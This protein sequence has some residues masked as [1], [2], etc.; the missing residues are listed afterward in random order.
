M[1]PRPPRS[2]LFPYT[3]LFRSSPE[4]SVRD[5]WIQVGKNARAISNYFGEEQKAQSIDNFWIMD[6][7]KDEP[8]SRLDP[9][10]RLI[11]SLDQINEEKYDEKNTMESYEGKLDRKSV[12]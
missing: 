2:T 1:I 10:E 7:M 8:I 9:R 5:Y 3:T 4:K 12:V 6:G 11:D